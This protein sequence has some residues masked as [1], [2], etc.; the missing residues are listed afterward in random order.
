MLPTAQAQRRQTRSRARLQL[1]SRRVTE[2]TDAFG[3]D[4]K[5]A[6]V[7]ASDIKLHFFSFL[8][9]PNHSCAYSRVPVREWETTSQ[10]AIGYEAPTRARTKAGSL[11][12]QF[13]FN[14]KASI[15]KHI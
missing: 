9:A 13:S 11:L 4:N 2:S 3:H 10:T 8:V 7:R 5:L 15:S 6:R 14:T 12:L 1:E